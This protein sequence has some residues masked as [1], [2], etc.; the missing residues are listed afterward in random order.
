MDSRQNRPA[1]A[2]LLPGT[3]R[4]P[5][6]AE[7]RAGGFEPVTVTDARDLANLVAM[8]RDV[9]AAVIDVEGDSDGGAATWCLLHEAGRDIPALLVV[10]PASFDQIDTSAEG[11]RNDEYLTRPYSAE[12]IRWRIE[13]MRIRAAAQDDGSGPVLQGDLE[14]EAWGQRGQM[15]AVFSPKGGVGKTTIAINLAAALRARD[16]RVLLV[17]AD[18]VSGH[19]AD[20]LRMTGVT[21]LVDAWRDELEGGPIQSCNEIAALHPSG[22]RVLSV[23]NDRVQTDVAD[24]ERVGLALATARRDVDFVIVDLHPSYSPLNRVILG[25]ADRVLVPTTPDLP[26]IRATLHLAGVAEGIGLRERLALVVN[27]G[28]SG[29]SVADVEKAAGLP[30][31]AQIRSSGLLM[32]KASNE[33]RTLVDMAPRERITGDFQALADSLLMISGPEPARMGLRLFGRSVARA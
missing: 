10:D 24:P 22:I 7:L 26:S 27:R 1:I 4:V 33:G 30:V 12:S 18:T 28:N 32:V 23:S 11:H 8:R 25:R 9:V 16:Q 20:S 19:V 29:V 14:H 31:Y 17:D 13:A 5:V 21:T 15:L 2:V 3:E 6:V